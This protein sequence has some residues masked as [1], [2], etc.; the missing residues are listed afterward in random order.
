MEKDLFK[1]NKEAAEAKSP[2]AKKVD[3]MVE[4]VTIDELPFYQGKRVPKGVK[5]SILES[6]FK[7]E[8]FKK[9]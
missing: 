5:L 6:A 4:V 2:A 7:K 9:I 8:L 3:K 1:D